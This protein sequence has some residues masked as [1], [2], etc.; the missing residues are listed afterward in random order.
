[1]VKCKHTQ[2]QLRIIRLP[3]V[4]V[5][6]QEV[7]YLVVLVDEVQ[8]LGHDGVALE[9]GLADVEHGLDHVLRTGLYGVAV[10]EDGTES[11]EYRC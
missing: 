7:G 4:G 1:M 6:L 2:L 9:F 11:L 10:V 3:I 8:L 5:Q